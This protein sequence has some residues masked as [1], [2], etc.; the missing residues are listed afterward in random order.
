MWM[1]G[2]QLACFLLLVVHIILFRNA[3][4]WTPMDFGAANGWHN[5]VKLLIEAE[6]NIC[7][8]DKMNVSWGF[9]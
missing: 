2:E 5:I 8:K 1:Q 3:I 9:F 7:P 4:L 6:A